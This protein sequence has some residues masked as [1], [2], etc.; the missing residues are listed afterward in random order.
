[1]N[2]AMRSHQLQRR[3]ERKYRQKLL[4]KNKNHQDVN[5]LMGYKGPIKYET[6][7][8]WKR[9]MNVDRGTRWV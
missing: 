3:F 1:M 8:S 4:R 6:E 2:I 5:T 7:S 9:L